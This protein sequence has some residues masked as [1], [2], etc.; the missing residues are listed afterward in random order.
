MFALILQFFVSA[1]AIIFAGSLLTKY[2][3]KIGEIT[4]WGRMFV[5]GLLIAGATSLPELMVDLESVFLNL[6]DLAVGDLLGSSLLNLL[7]L[8]ILDFSFPSTFRRTVFSPS[9][10]HHAL[11]AVLGITLSSV[12]GIGITSK[13]DHSIFGVSIFFWAVAALY[14]FGIRLIFKDSLVKFE[15][16]SQQ[17]DN[18]PLR[19]LFSR[20][21]FI[22]SLIG[23][24]V[25]G[26]I[27]LLAAPYLITS[28]KQIAIVSGLS[29]TFIGTTL[30]ALTTSLPELV[31]TF[32]AFKMGKPDLAL[33]NIFG[34]NA[35]NMLFFVPLDL[36]F[37]GS[38]IATINIGHSVTVLSVISATSIA[39]MGQLYR[40]KDRALF[41]EPSSE[42]VVTAI[43]IFLLILYVLNS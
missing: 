7:I 13:L 25:S 5:G 17:V 32:T 30:L 22:S 35:F 39:V 24:F 18:V 2:A 14:F 15:S 27:I 9:F 31:S 4:G 43:V 23:Y 12:I 8:S 19:S 29:F 38:L 36:A 16:L 42:I 21:D 20:S 26:L 34:S 41:S 40:K 33:G 37:P 11:I 1:I 28:T 6:P 10:L 3:D